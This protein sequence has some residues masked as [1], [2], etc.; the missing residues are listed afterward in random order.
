MV[1]SKSKTLLTDHPTSQ[2]WFQNYK[3]ILMSYLYS[4]QTNCKVAEISEKMRLELV[5][6]VFSLVSFL[7]KKKT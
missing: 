1:K 3:N 7:K 6:V 4:I 2:F 5:S